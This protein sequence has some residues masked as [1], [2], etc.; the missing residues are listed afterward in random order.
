MDFSN[1]FY[2]DALWLSIAFVSGLLAKRIG[3]PPLVG[4]LAAG[5]VINFSGVQHCEL[6][7]VIKP[8]ADIGVMLLLFTIGLKLKVKSLLKK[9][10]WATASIHMLV[11][12][13]LFSSLILFLSYLGLTQ[14]ADMSWQSA[15]MISFALSFS[16]TVFVVKTLESRGEFDSYHGK[17]AIGILIIQDI[18]AVLFIA[19]SD[20]KLP[21][22]WVF[23]LPFF[24][25]G[26]QKVLSKLL[27]RLDHGE[28]VPVFGFFTT[29]IAGAL[30][31]SLVGL[32][33]DLG[34]LV[35][36][37]LLVNHPRADELYKRMAEYKDF[38][39]IAFFINVGLIGLPGI[40]TLIIAA[41]LL[42][43]V[44]I[45]GGL[46][47]WI[48]SRFSLQP[49]TAYLGALS[50]T[51]F[52]E[53][54]LIVGVIGLKMG[55]ISNDWLLAMAILMSFSFAVA[56]PLNNYSHVIFNKFKAAILKLNK[57]KETEDCEPVDLGEAQYLVIGLG[58]IG[59]PA[60]DTLREKYGELVIGIDY[61]LEKIS[62]LREKGLNVTWGDSTD[63]VL[64][65]NVDTSSL[66]A[67]F[68]TMSDVDSNVNILEEI[69]RLKNRNF[70]VHAICHYE[71]QK[72]LYLS[73]GAD[74]VFDFKNYI[75][76]D[77]VE[78]ALTDPEN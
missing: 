31:F 42:P 20:K 60:F 22:P 65:D 15:A 25:W 46:F 23:T 18:F 6:S 71:D 28:M 58:S 29:F 9:E 53:F 75:G 72:E 55:L 27:D 21:S 17:I 43:L 78:Q 26:L 63:S 50:L 4:F 33:P 37:M 34:A 67:V 2:I 7:S 49:R 10:I 59:K 77:Y 51:N 66:K 35:I 38:F 11:I 74:F 45:K 14:F 5:F 70:K 52:S 40:D 48:L 54:G 57:N 44:F 41:I 73:E 68:L 8:M 39:L 3:L 13:L 62:S 64:W 12:I 19:L 30:S 61:N 36:G 1:P 16:S 32:K 24:L 76:K 56:A 69:S 47:L